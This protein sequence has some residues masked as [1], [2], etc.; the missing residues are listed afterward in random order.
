[1]KIGWGKQSGAGSQWY[2]SIRSLTDDD[3]ET[4]FLESDCRGRQTDRQLEG[5]CI[6]ACSQVGFRYEYETDRQI[7]RR[8]LGAQKMYLYCFVSFVIVGL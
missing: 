1:M 7:G 3:T 5:A 2:Y 4:L 8:E 6:H